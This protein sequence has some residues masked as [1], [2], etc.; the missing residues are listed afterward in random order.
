MSNH[1]EDPRQSQISPTLIRSTTG[2]SREEEHAITEHQVRGTHWTEEGTRRSTRTSGSRGATPVHRVVHDSENESNHS[3]TSDEESNN[4]DGPDDMQRES[5]ASSELSLPPPPTQEDD[6][7]SPPKR[8][9]G[10]NS[11]PKLDTTTVGENKKELHFQILE[12][13][14]KSPPKNIA[15]VPTTNQ[16][17]VIEAHPVTQAGPK[18]GPYSQGTDTSATVTQTVTTAASATQASEKLATWLATPEEMTHVIP[19][20]TTTISHGGAQSPATLGPVSRSQ[21]VITS[22]TTVIVA[23][24]LYHHATSHIILRAPFPFPVYGQAL[25]LSLIHI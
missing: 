8:P 24:S 23:R 20:T 18:I 16:F 15:V 3:F 1:N 17:Q 5:S 14:G 19:T 4:M 13:K 10:H 22:H 21:Q 25:P 12:A 11:P 2:H 6:N 7:R 9:P